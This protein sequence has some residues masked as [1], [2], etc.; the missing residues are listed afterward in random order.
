VKQWMSYAGVALK[1]MTVLLLSAIGL[2]PFS[3][4]LLYSSDALWVVYYVIYVVTLV[5]FVVI[6]PNQPRYRFHV[7]ILFYVIVLSVMPFHLSAHIIGLVFQGE[8]IDVSPMLEDMYYPIAIIIEL[9]YHSA[10]YY[11]MLYLIARLLR[12]R[13]DVTSRS[14]R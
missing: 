10:V 14:R 6:I 12:K 2:L 7:I 8:S 3:L 5:S 4:R 11:I 1:G 9:F 13:I